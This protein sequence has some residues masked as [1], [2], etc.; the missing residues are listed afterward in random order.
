MMVVLVVL[1]VM[2]VM[3]MW[4]AKHIQHHATNCALH[5]SSIV[6]T[7]TTIIT[8][9]TKPCVARQGESRKSLNE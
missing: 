1:V 9:A 8:T 7:T 5:D 4:L 3:V 6:D 2:M